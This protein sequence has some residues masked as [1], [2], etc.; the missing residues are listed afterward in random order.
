[1][2][3]F[4]HARALPRLYL[5]ALICLAGSPALWATTQLVVQAKT[6]VDGKMEFKSGPCL[7][8]PAPSGNPQQMPETDTP[9][10]TVMVNL[11]RTVSGNYGYFVYEFHVEPKSAS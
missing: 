8:E 7:P 2:L 6:L 5:G 11:G 10:Y 4:P 3:S 1:M 9:N